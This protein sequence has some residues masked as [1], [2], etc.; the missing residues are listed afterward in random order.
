MG[1]TEVRQGRLMKGQQPGLRDQ[2]YLR[3][4]EQE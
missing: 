2:T 4:F 3:A 1:V